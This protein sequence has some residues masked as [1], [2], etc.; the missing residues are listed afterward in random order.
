MKQ[1]VALFAALAA[2]VAGP[3]VAL[4]TP[5][6]DREEFVRY[7]NKKFPNLKYED[8]I[9]GALALN[10][11]AKTQYDTIM[12]F[13]PFLNELD[14]GKK[15]WETPF[16]NGR[17]YASCFPDGGRNVVGNY[18]YFDDKLGK[19][20]TFEMAINMCREAN[21]E[22]P[23]KHS[24]MKTMGVLTAYAR[25]LS[26]G[27]KVNV[28]VQGP[29]AMKAY[30]DGKKFFYTRRGQ[31]NFACSTCHVDN[32]GNTL[33]TELLSP[34]LGHATHWPVFRQGT[35]LVTLHKRYAGCLE[36]V[37]AEPLPEGST[38][39]NNLEYFHTYMSN[40]LEIRSSVF[41]K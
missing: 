39:F 10:P 11:D 33:R 37:R 34:A 38:E 6:Q 22:H 41:R 13:P 36:Q 26:D 19:V 8:Y 40:G 24:D 2:L 4:A 30:E 9:F 20:V 21:G 1:R 32:G 25:T 27:M 29:E 16:K 17:T 31:L 3:S 35:N 23:Y 12:E 18:P 15:M 28:K 7:F 14:H 5:E